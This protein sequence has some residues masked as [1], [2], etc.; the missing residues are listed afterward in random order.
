MNWN[1]YREVNDSTFI[2]SRERIT[3]TMKAEQYGVQNNNI[4][5]HGNNAGCN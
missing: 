2:V 3:N 1:D 5:K 4:I